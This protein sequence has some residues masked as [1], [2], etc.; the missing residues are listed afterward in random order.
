MKRLIILGFALLF[1]LPGLTAQ[2]LTEFSEEPNAFIKELREFMTSSK[3]KT[4]E[5]LFDNF[6]KVFK[7]GRFSPE[8]FK[9]IRATSNMMLSQRMTASPYFSKYLLA[10]AIVKDGELGETRFKEWHRILDHL[11]A[12]IENRKLKPFER[13]LEFSQAFFERNAF[14]YSR[15]GTTWIADGPRYDFEIED[16]KPVVKYDKLNLIA[17]RGKDSIM[18]QETSGRYYPVEEIWRGQ[19]GK[20]TWER[21]G[22]NKDVYAELG[23]YELQTNKSLYEVKSVKMHYPL[24][25]GDLAVPG[26]FR[27]KLS[28]ANRA[29]EGSYPRFESHE[30]IL[31]IKNIGQGVKYTGGFRLHGMTV[32]GF[33]SK[34]NK[35]RI[36][37]YNDDN[38]LAYRGRAELFTI[39]REE[40]IVG[41]R[42]ESTVYFGQDSLY[43]PSVNIRFEI[44][45]K[46][47]QLSRGQR[48]SDRNPFYNS[49]HQVN[50]DANNIDYHLATDSIYI[51][52]TNLGFQ[53]TLTPVSFESLKYFE[54]GDYQR[55]QNIAT[56]NPI[57]LMKIASRENGGKRTLDANELA[58]RLNPRF[59][60]ENVSSLLYDLVSKGFINY[61]ADKQEVELKDKI[62]HYADAALKKVDY[63]VLRITSE[64]TGTNAVFDLKDQ[65]IWINGVK[66]IELSALQKVGFLPKNNQ[67]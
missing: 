17:T 59:T 67:I 60:V 3:R 27:D 63:D 42:V 55:I 21:Y 56:T 64:T 31:E 54:L 9:M 37:I 18:I 43:H 29:S 15:T 12:N 57:A 45:T 24:Y 53:K 11:L 38:E 35:A 50:I 30:E 19:G 13:F 14:R 28:A 25:F 23:E 52:K 1:I 65:T 58:K 20:V 36:L 46:Q 39:R 62:F 7:S 33:G 61:D 44:P 5:E 49:L 51:G 48:G 32:Y 2:R 34:E 41:E 16:N 6:E 10:L 26:S 66:H 40:R 47:L 8:E 22:L 4:M